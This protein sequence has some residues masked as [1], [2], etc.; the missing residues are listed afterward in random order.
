MKMEITMSL[1]EAKKLLAKSIAL[2]TV[3]TQHFEVTEVDWKS[4]STSVVFTLETPTAPIE[5]PPSGDTL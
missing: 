5:P 1:D 4:Y 2:T 3:G